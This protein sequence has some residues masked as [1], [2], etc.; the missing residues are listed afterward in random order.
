MNI[1]QPDMIIKDN[2][3]FVALKQIQNHEYYEIIK[4]K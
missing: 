4:L 2:Y 3:I 1:R